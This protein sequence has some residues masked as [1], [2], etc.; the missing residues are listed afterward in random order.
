MEQA[1]NPASRVR[2]SQHRDT[3]G[4]RR[5]ILDWQLTGLERD[6]YGQAGE[7]FRRAFAR[8]GVGRV[9]NLER[10]SDADQILHSNHHL[11]TTRMAD[12]PTDGVVDA[13]SRVHGIRNLY[14]MG[15]GI[16]PTVSWA[17]PTLTLMALTF[18]LAD[19]FRQTLSTSI[20][21]DA[22]TR[23]ECDGDR[24]FTH[25]GGHS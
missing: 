13:E 25:R 21:V 2:L 1:P 7:L 14:I 6:T 9:T 17:N 24:L 3:L 23:K 8:I 16:Y 5:I 4:M 15:G 12:A 20:E 11:G 18:R 19:R 10:S 22:S